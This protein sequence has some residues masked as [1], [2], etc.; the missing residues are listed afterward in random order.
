MHR[1]VLFS[2]GNPSGGSIDLTRGPKRKLESFVRP[3]TG[4]LSAG[5]RIATRKTSPRFPS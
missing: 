4:P 5:A 3:A 1:T 2:L